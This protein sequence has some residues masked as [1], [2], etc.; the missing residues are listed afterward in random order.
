LGTWPGNSCNRCRET[1]LGISPDPK[2]LD[3]PETGMIREHWLAGGWL[4]YQ[5]VQF[6]FPSGASV[7]FVRN[8]LPIA[9]SLLLAFQAFAE[10]PAPDQKALFASYVN[11]SVYRA[12]LEQIFNSGEPAVL[13]AECP[14]LKVVTQNRVNVV[15]Q[16]TF[17]RAGTNFNIDTGSWVAVGVL[18]RCGA[19]VTRRALVKAIPG[20]NQLRPVFLLPGDFRGNLKLEA[21]AVRIVTPALMAFSKCKDWS[22]FQ[23]INVAPITPASAS[24]W[25]ET[26][27]AV[28]CDAKID[29]E[30]T[31]AATGDGMN[32]SAGK[33]K[34]H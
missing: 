10:Q 5:G 32:I 26:W 31:Y 27:T 29:A 30:V 16:P 12:Y 4:C 14:A 8:I 1:D 11:S 13:K 34:V 22:K 3:G 15:D 21:D 33:W 7:M 6:N 23:V 28:A 25:S 24:G 19:Q 2:F 18:D 17:V 9:A 20:A